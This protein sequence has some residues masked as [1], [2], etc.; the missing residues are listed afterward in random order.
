FCS[1]SEAL[2]NANSH[3]GANID[4]EPGSVNGNAIQF[5]L[6]GTITILTAAANAG[7]QSLID[8]TGRKIVLDGGGNPSGVRVLMTT[9]TVELTNLTIANGFA[10]TNQNQD[11]G[12]VLNTGSLNIQNSTFKTN[13]A[14]KGGAIKST[15]RVS[16]NNTTF[17]GNT[18]SSGSGGAIYS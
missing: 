5:N 13:T 1:L 17:S 8:G 9:G 16:A 7:D 12:G 10:G 14:N 18:A 15:S 4:C 2:D 11:G 6:S 3:S